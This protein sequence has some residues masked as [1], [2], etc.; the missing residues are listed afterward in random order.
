MADFLIS[1]QFYFQGEPLI[2]PRLPEF[3][4]MVHTMKIHTVL[5]TNAHFLDDEKA[6]MLVESGLDELIISLDGM[7]AE[8]YSAYRK[9]GDIQKVFQG[10]KYI[11]EKKK[12]FRSA[13]PKVTLQFLVFRHNEQE[14]GL[15]LDYA[16]KSGADRWTLKGPQVYDLK[17]ADR[18]IPSDPKY[19]RYEKKNGEWK[20]RNSFKNRCYRM[21]TG[22][23]ITWDGYVVPC[24]FDKDAKYKM[25]NIREQSWEEIRSSPAYRSFVQMLLNSR[26]EIDICRNCTEGTNG[27]YS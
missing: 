13:R 10:I 7:S 3:I 27:V 11:M 6:R 24:C 8:T 21:W 12:Q 1:I 16:R 17:D 25:G 5:S 23:V 18:W 19:A 2:H 20:I 15:F 9:E 14:V 4:R 26:K 22:C